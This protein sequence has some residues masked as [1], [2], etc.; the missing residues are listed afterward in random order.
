[1][2]LGLPEGTRTDRIERRAGPATSDDAIGVPG[3]GFDQVGGSSVLT[4]ADGHAG[5]HVTGVTLDLANG[6]RVEATV[7]NGFYAA[8]WPSQ[9]DV[10]AAEVTSS[11]GPGH[12][13]FGDI[14]P[15][16]PARRAF[17]REPPPMSDHSAIRLR[18]DASYLKCHRFVTRHTAR[19]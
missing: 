2:P 5:A 4:Y 14:G 6:V 10:T 17:S 1:M 8:W 11:E 12:Q 7:Q 18:T 19:A 3:V 9:S 13:D 15:N 16:N